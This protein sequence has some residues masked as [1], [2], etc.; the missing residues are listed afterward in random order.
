MHAS[1]EPNSQSVCES[2]IRRRFHLCLGCI[3]VI[4]F[5]LLPACILFH[6]NHMWNLAQD[7]A[8]LIITPRQNLLRRLASSRPVQTKENIVLL[9]TVPSVIYIIF[10]TC[11]YFKRNLY[12]PIPLE[13]VRNT[14]AEYWANT[15][16]GSAVYCTRG[17]VVNSPPSSITLPNFRHGKQLP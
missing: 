12:C 6:R 13:P 10:G 16:L 14:R 2:R 4:I 9:Y 7:W 17:S 8:A 11:T 15:S 1:T 3:G 5:Q